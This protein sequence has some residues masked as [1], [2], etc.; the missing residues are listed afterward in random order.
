MTN[1]NWLELQIARLKETGQGLYKDG[2]LVM[3]LKTIRI[4]NDSDE[5]V[6]KVR[7]FIRN[8]TK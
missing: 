4:E 6:Q 8:N 3:G 7:E 2:L 5:T 1:K